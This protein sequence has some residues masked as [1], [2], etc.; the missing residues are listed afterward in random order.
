MFFVFSKA[1]LFHVK[2]GKSGSNVYFVLTKS[3]ESNNARLF[4]LRLAVA[5]ATQK[6]LPSEMKSQFVCKVL[7]HQIVAVDILV[8]R[9]TTVEGL[10][11]CM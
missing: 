10:L 11:E 7:I 5:N 8:G 3:L 4:F 9:E 1:F 2:G 6:K